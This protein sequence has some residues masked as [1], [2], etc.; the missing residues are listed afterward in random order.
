MKKQI[1]LFLTLT[2]PVLGHAN[3]G[4][5]PYYYFCDQNSSAQAPTVNYLDGEYDMEI[6]INNKIFHDRVIIQGAAHS[7]KMDLNGAF[8]IKGSVEVVNGFLAP[9]VGKATCFKDWLGS[10]CQINFEITATENGQKFKVRYF[11]E[12][13][14][15]TYQAIKSFKIE[16]SFEGS[17]ELENGKILG[18]FKASIIKI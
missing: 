18:N 10:T 9:L 7:L 3:C 8:D 12:F 16:P 4:R 5:E 6:R 17:A 13:P 14:F 1:L 15:R 2:I 11:G